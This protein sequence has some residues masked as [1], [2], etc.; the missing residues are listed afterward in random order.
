M[1]KYTKKL[2][3]EDLKRFAK[4]ISKKMV[5]SD[6]KKRRVNDPT[7]I[8]RDKEKQVKAYVGEFFDKAVKKRREHEKSKREKERQAHDSR[9]SAVD[10]AKNGEN[11][12]PADTPIPTPIDGDVDDDEEVTMDM[13]EDEDG[14]ANMPT[15]RSDDT[16]ESRK[17]KHDAEHGV[18]DDTEAKRVKDDVAA[19]GESPTPPPPP[20]PPPQESAEDAE[21]RAAQ[22][23][24]EREN[25][26]A[27]AMEAQAP[28]VV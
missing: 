14:D 8:S 13:S 10:Q 6:Y 23:A 26:E 11:D 25:E 7:H 9:M 18:G 15:G 2:P 16:D 5:A 12:T 20:P 3:K 17:R 19:N 28:G 1:N 21:L 27:A 22:E 24:L 4:D